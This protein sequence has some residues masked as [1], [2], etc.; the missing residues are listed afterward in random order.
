[1]QE[2]VRLGDGVRV[3]R[4]DGVRVSFFVLGEK[5]KKDK[6]KIQEKKDKLLIFF[7]ALVLITALAFVGAVAALSVRVM[8]RASDALA[9]E[10]EKRDGQ[11]SGK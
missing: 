4:G 1:M 3:R 2:K 5:M 6:T 11:R 9:R 8:R 7:G 10:K